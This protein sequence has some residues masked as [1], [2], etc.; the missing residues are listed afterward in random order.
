MN[1]ITPYKNEINLRKNFTS[2]LEIYNSCDCESRHAIKKTGK[3]S[4]EEDDLRKEE[5][6]LNEKETY[7]FL[8]QI[9]E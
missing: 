3:L 7:I 5:D 9:D 1:L 2:L 4:E 6:G 8:R